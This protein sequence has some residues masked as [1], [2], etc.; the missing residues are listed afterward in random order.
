M[1]PFPPAPTCWHLAPRCG[2]AQAQLLQWDPQGQVPAPC[3]AS[4]I[5]LSLSSA[6]D[7]FHFSS[8]PLAGDARGCQCS[9]F[10]SLLHFWGFFRAWWGSP[11]CWDEFDGVSPEAAGT[12]GDAS[13][14][15]VPVPTFSV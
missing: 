15:A 13:P 5:L 6:E 4:H 9:L 7:I 14:G 11:G 3:P 12:W 1:R 8:C 2:E 10:S